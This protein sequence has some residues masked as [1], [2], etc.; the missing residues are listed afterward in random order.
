[1][2]TLQTV[3]R[4]LAQ[5][6]DKPA[7]VTL[8][9]HE[10]AVWSFA[11][12]ADL[13]QR[14]A[15]GLTAAGMERGARAV[16]MAPNG[17]E[18]ILACLALMAAAAVPV[19]VDNQLSDEDLR[20][21]LADS[22]ARWVFTSSLLVRRISTG[23]LKRAVTLVLLDAP[24]NDEHSWRRSLAP[25]VPELPSAAPDDLAVLFYTSGTT[26][27]PKGVPL[28]H[29]NLTANLD[30][31]LSL[32]LLQQGQYGEVLAKGPN[33][34]A[35]Y[36]HLPEKTKAAFTS[37]GYF[38]T[39]DVG[40]FDADGYLHLV[41]RASEMIVL[42]GGENVRPE[43][44]EEIL[45]HGEH[46]REAG[47]LAYEGRLAALIVPDTSATH[48]PDEAQAEEAIRREVE[49]LSQALPS[50]HRI[51]EYALT[52]DP[53]PRTRLG[54]IRR[55]T[56]A[57]R[58]QQA[59]RRGGPALETGPLPLTQMS[60][61]DRQLLEDGTAQRV[62][63]WLARRFPNVRLTPDAHVRLDLGVDSLA[64]LNLTLEIRECAGVDL[65]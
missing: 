60:L 12:L 49:H 58:Y 51:S 16:V 48:P 20:H 43:I 46:I 32:G 34:F 10:L 38:R 28:T 50:H 44:I 19:P 64:W 41:G 53:L 13:V 8:R 62:W 40:Y 35:G 31:L 47:V 59:K 57:E 15:T 45:A 29:R 54:K 55:Y 7:V 21:V 3:V 9:K 42:S 65:D 2:D 23:N 27:A 24:D 4:T 37:D 52:P 11:H 17:P 22:E 30:A 36:V 18:W 25:T 39:G 63:E 1:M 6:G 14:L 61:E 56:L 26:G 5:H 33:V